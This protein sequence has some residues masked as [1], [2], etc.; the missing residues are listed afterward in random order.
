MAGAFGFLLQIQSRERPERY[1][2]SRRLV[3][4]RAVKRLS[5]LA[6]QRAESGVA[7]ASAAV[8]PRACIIETPP[9]V[10]G[11]LGRPGRCHLYQSH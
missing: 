2:E 11:K 3:P 5:R 6:W 1:G 8:P 10:Y 4:A 9:N 7:Q